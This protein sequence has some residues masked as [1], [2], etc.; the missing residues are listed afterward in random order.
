MS[1]VTGKTDLVTEPRAWLRRWREFLYVLK[2]CRFSV[3]M[4]A[5]GFLL[6]WT[7][8]GQDILVA[9]AEDGVWRAQLFFIPALI[10]AS[11]AWYWARVMLDFRFPDP[12]PESDFLGGLRRHLPRV[13]GAGAFV[14]IAINLWSAREGTH[15]EVEGRL[16]VLVITALVWALVFYLA[17]FYRR[18]WVRA[19]WPAA[20]TR[21]AAGSRWARLFLT[22]LAL[23]EPSELPYTS[24]KQ[25][26]GRN[27]GL[28]LA[29]SALFGG[30]LFFASWF[31]P[32]S[33]GGLFGPAVL[34]FLW[35]GTWI[36]LGS[37]LVYWS[38]QTGVPVLTGLFALALVFSLWNDN[39]TLREVA[40]GQDPGQRPTV[41]DAAKA[42]AD[43]QAVQTGGSGPAG[44]KVP[45]VIVATA[46]GGSRA[47]YW[48]ATVLGHLQDTI[49]DFERHLFAVSG[50]SGG[51]VGAATYRA[52]LAERLSRSDDNLC[53]LPNG[54]QTTSL[55]DCAQAVIG[56]NFLGPAV[57]GA[58]YPD[59]AQ[60][61]LPLPHP[62]G[63]PDRAAALEAGWEAAFEQAMEGG[64][65]RFAQSLLRLY[66]EQTPAGE[67]SWPALFLNGT[68]VENG[69]RIIASNLKLEP[70]P[71]GE[72]NKAFI[73]A[74]DLLARIGR[75]VPLSTAADSS[76]RFPGVGP[77]GTLR[78]PKTEEVFGRVVDGGYFENF[79]AVTAREILDVAMAEMGPSIR[80]VVIQIGSDPDLPEDFAE[81][82]RP[83]PLVFAHEIQA[84]LRA[85]LA[86]RHARGILAAK[87][88]EH[89]T[90]ETYAEQDGL[91]VHFRMC[92]EEGVSD[93]P[94]GWMLSQYARRQIGRYLPADSASP[95]VCDDNLRALAKL[96]RAFQVDG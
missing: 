23:P 4:V 64:E 34:F 78:S 71:S 72:S 39:H 94:L 56:G 43:T 8:Q 93:P 75:D 18:T 10:W 40:E 37:V 67:G 66:R 81:L 92:Q 91:F 38:N 69:R 12:P 74:Y 87:E 19:L 26:Y 44:G 28:F 33:V 89:R 31:A 57:A 73:T 7:D 77:A 55:R 85:A 1:S 45:L 84:P 25:L 76:A 50:V 27:T 82:G 15:A 61:F 36:P 51:S 13:L 60:R 32:V 48:T 63:L 95:P 30:S 14:V 90:E 35:A 70:G 5:A 52:V 11:N 80:P 47:A 59:L 6:L 65:P 46:G 3:L 21:A 68:W 86:A 16:S 24:W 17:V 22:L 54:E 42:W 83:Q 62:Y 2:L 41:T 20:E 53:R 79:G 9:L 88:L 58:L 96:E 49:P 29:L